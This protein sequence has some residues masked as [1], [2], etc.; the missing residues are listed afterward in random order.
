MSK[1]PALSTTLATLSITA[2]TNNLD[3][4]FEIHRVI[5]GAT[6]PG[7]PEFVT[8][9][10]SFELLAFIQLQLT[11]FTKQQIL[12]GAPGLPVQLVDLVKGPDDL[13]WEWADPYYLERSEG[14]TATTKIDTFTGAGHNNQSVAPRIA[15]QGFLVGLG[16]AS[17]R[18][19]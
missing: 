8:A 16:P 15:F 13:S 12:A 14:L 9:A 17:D 4:P 18:R 7:K 10:F 1:S 3:R 19:G 5:F 2:L 6:P 11:D